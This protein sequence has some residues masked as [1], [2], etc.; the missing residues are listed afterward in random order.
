MR[1]Y[2]QEQKA[3]AKARKQTPAYKAKA[4]AYDKAYNQ[5][6]ERKAWL[7]LHCQ[8][9]EWKAQRESIKRKRRETTF[10][11]SRV[12]PWPT[13]CMICGLPFEGSWPEGRSE[14]IGHEP[15]I[16]W[17]LRHPEYDGALVLRPEHSS[18]NLKKSAKPDWEC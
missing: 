17:M 16:A 18:C 10:T 12:D 3:R 13:D 7:K 1:V 9:L 15:P 11:W 5:T 6:P 14:T 2:T 4:K 8:T